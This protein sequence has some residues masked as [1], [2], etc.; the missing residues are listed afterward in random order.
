MGQRHNVQIDTTSARYSRNVAF[1]NNYVDILLLGLDSRH[2]TQPSVRQGLKL[3]CNNYV[4]ALVFGNTF[5]LKI[6]ILLSESLK[7]SLILGTRSPGVG[8]PV[9]T[10]MVWFH[11]Q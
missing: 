3:Y 1:I 4:I 6:N 5:S 9:V 8:A 2:K 7:R 11:V 10:L